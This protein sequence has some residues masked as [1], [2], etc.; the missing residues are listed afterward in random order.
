MYPIKSKTGRTPP[1]DNVQTPSWLGKLLT[2]HFPLSGS[3]LEPCKG[4]GG[5]Y[6]HLPSGSDWCEIE[7]GRDYFDIE[8]QWDY[9]IS[10][11][12]YSEYY[13]WME[14]HFSDGRNVITIV[15]A[16]KP[17]NSVGFMQMA[18]D[19]GNIKEIYVI[20]RVPEF[21]FGFP[22]AAVHYQRGYRGKTLFSY[23]DGKRTRNERGDV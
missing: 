15:P 2:E 11:P 1:N 7:E 20:G 9:I 23:Y 14:K 19:Y 12:P 22:V 17:F 4:K 8:G 10:N 3:I 6:D 5:I 13:P 21:P 18:R 16:A